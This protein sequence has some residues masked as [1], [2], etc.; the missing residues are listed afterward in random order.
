MLKGDYDKGGLRMPDVKILQES[1][2]LEWVSKLYKA[3]ETEKWSFIPFATL[4]K[5]GKDLACFRTNVSWKKFKTDHIT[6]TP[7]WTEVLKTWSLVIP[8]QIF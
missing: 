7:F 5:Y 6:L 2:L 8:K 3:K 1:F 4:L